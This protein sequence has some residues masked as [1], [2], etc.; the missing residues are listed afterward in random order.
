MKLVS[1]KTSRSE[2]EHL[3]P[4]HMGCVAHTRRPERSQLRVSRRERSLRTHIL[5]DL[6][7]HE[8]GHD[9]DVLDVQR[10][11]ALRQF[12]KHCGRPVYCQQYLRLGLEGAGFHAHLFGHCAAR[13]YQTNM[14]HII[15]SIL[16]AFNIS[17]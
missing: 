13:V 15:R 2:S 3:G 5:S 10:L 14:L 1:A 6:L 9:A 8:S 7:L 17:L 4:V 12:R 16:F 11:S